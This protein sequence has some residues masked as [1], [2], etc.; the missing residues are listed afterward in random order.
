MMPVG[1]Q[2][3]KRHVQVLGHRMAYIEEGRGAPVVFLHGNPTSS[4]LWRS[5]IPEL[6]GH[7]RC[8]APDLIGMGRQAPAGRRSPVHV[9]AAP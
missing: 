2:Q 1:W 3:S 5:V 9:H 7:G 8:I 4:Y 6:A